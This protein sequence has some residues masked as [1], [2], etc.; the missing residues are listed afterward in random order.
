[1]GSQSNPS[2]D[3]FDAEEIFDKVINL[4]Q[5]KRIEIISK[6]KELTQKFEVQVKEQGKDIVN[7]KAKDEK[8]YSKT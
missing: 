7:L 5:Q 6:K 8:D 3:N 1:M 2:E 4:P